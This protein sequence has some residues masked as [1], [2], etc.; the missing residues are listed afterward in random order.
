MITPDQ[1]EYEEREHAPHRRFNLRP[2]VFSALLLI[3]PAIL[4]STTGELFLKVGMNQIGGFEFNPGAIMPIIPKLIVNPY[5]WIG[6]IGFLGGSV[7]W[8]GVLSRAPLSLA[9]PMLALSYFV[10]VIE[11]WLFLGEQVTWQRMLGVLIIFIGVVIVGLSEGQ[12]NKT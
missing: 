7:F 1:I 8:L 11:A 10:V 5:I 6:F 4:L 12:I 9:Y 2:E 3:I